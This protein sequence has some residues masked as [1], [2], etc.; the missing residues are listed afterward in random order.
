MAITKDTLL[1]LAKKLISTRN[2]KIDLS[3][4]TVLNDLG[5]DSTAQ[6]LATLSSDIDRIVGQQSLDANYFTDEEADIFVQPFGLTRNAAVKATGTVTFATNTLPSASSPIVI[7]VGTTV[8]SQK[9]TGSATLNYVTTTS[10][11]ITNSSP[12]NSNTGYYEVSVGIQ[13][14]SAGEEYNVGIGYINGLKNSISGVNAVYN[15]NAILNGS[16]VETTASLL[17]RFLILWRGRNRNTEPGILA[18]TYENPVVE[19]A[20][21]VGPNSDFTLR[22][23][24]SIDVYVR[25]TTETSYVQTVTQMTTEVL[26]DRQPI[27]HP[28]SLYVTINGVNYTEDDGV[29]VIVKDTNTIFQSSC[30]AMDKLVWTEEGKHLIDNLDSYTITFSYN[31]LI[32]DLQTMYDTDSG[33]LVTGN[34]LAR[35]T[36]QVDLIMEFGITPIS[37]YDKASVITLVKTNI[38]SYINTTK[39][40]TDIKQ[41]DIVAIIEA[42]DGVSY[43]D[44]PFAQFHKVGETDENKLVADI[45]ATPLEYFRID[46]ENIII[47]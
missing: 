17:E 24:G 9:D 37:G 23:P 7:P 46:S 21:V 12:L 16:D 40:N 1:S 39:L 28:D 38:Q 45:D 18:W 8:Y 2:N 19:E 15:K 29:F 22:G 6:I 10:G 26:F 25:G 20:L 4:G 14:V 11:S 43:T 30:D 35:D 36:K 32:S 33:R 3:T 31:S 41:S 42:T 5:V 34:I 44:L 47:G 27:I 13:A